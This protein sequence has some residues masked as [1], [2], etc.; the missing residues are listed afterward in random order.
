LVYWNFSR[1]LKYNSHLLRIVEQKPLELHQTKLHDKVF[2]KEIDH[3]F[4]T[5]NLENKI[6]IMAQKLYPYM[7][8]LKIFFI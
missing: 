1:L 2:N 8:L 7:F 4:N 3:P 5:K 6:I